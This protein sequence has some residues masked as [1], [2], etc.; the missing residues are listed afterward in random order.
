[1]ARE[2]TEQEIRDFIAAPQEGLREGWVTKALDAATETRLWVNTEGPQIVGILVLGNFADADPA[3]WWVAYMW[4]DPGHPGTSPWEMTEQAIVD[5]GAEGHIF[6]ID[7]P[8]AEG[9][10]TAPW[11]TSSDDPVAPPGP[12]T[13]GYFPASR[14]FRLLGEGQTQ[15]GTFYCTKAVNTGWEPS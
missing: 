7:C 3:G 14:P 1:M 13:Y 8:C 6:T 15:G 10:C 11:F 9:L 12:G 4:G 2:A 5:L